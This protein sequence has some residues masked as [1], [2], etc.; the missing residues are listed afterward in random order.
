MMVA[1]TNA[2]K[3]PTIALEDSNHVADFHVRDG[4]SASSSYY[5]QILAVESDSTHSVVTTLA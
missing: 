4:S 2:D 1:A 5:H 3:A